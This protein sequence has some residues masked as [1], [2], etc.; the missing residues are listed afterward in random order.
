[1][2]VL[3]VCLRQLRQLCHSGRRRVCGPF[4][5]HI[6][7]GVSAPPYGKQT[8][9]GP[10]CLDIFR[11]DPGRVCCYAMHLAVYQHVEVKYEF[12][13]AEGTVFVYIVQVCYIW[14]SLETQPLE[15]VLWF[16]HRKFEF[17][18]HEKKMICLVRAQNS[19]GNFGIGIGIQDLRVLQPSMAIMIVVILTRGTPRVDW[20]FF[21]CPPTCHVS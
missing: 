10:A 21:P 17:S 3:F 1:M 8:V 4:G 11:F 5:A 2:I 13:R 15:C 16:L 18:L 7:S 19:V 9:I 20:R 14:C 6:P 12:D